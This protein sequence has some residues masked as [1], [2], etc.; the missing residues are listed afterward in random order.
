MD[1]DSPLDLQSHTK[2]KRLTSFGEGPWLSVPVDAAKP[3]RRRSTVAEALVND[4]SDYK[5]LVQE[6]LA[7][8][9]QVQNLKWELEEIKEIQESYMSSN[10]EAGSQ[11][12]E[13]NQ[14]QKILTLTQKQLTIL[15]SA[16]SDI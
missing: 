6:K 13:A 15:N 16:A 3:N 9:L 5:Q 8:K 11:I 7:L 4:F 1:K 14:S 12:F 2:L 10:F